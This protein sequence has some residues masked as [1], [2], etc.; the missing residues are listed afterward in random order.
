MTNK[1]E[2]AR[3]RAGAAVVDGFFQT[4]SRLGRLHPMAR[5]ERHGVDVVRNLAYAEDSDRPEHRL[6]VYRPRDAREKLPAVL[7]VHGGG[8][9]ILSKDTHWV[10]GLAFA[11]RGYVVFNVGYRLAPTHR[12]PAA[13]EDV[14]AA[15]EWMVRHAGEWGA[16]LDRLVIAGESAG[17]NLAMGLTFSTLFERD[18]PFAKR[19]HE[20]GVVPKI[21]L[22][23]C[24][25]HQVTDGARFLRRKPHLPRVVLDRIEEVEHA[26]LGS[27]PTRHG[28]TLDF[29]DPLLW[30]ERASPPKRPLPA[31]FLPVGTRDPV[32]DDTRRMAKALRD[33]GA[34]AEDR[35]YV[36]EVHAFHAFAFRKR[37][38]QC[39]ADTYAFLDAHLPPG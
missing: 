12:F 14:S 34:V 27:D 30:A 28:T 23:A 25:I 36:G 9:R 7:Y 1:L 32:L 8:F 18:E 16:D 15:F 19:V 6:D 11:R 33:L 35:Y 38:R 26:Y 10:M 17:A 22:P 5:P 21:V 39:W 31:F 37:A 2:E 24:G 29:A 4:M 20:T 3:R 13:V